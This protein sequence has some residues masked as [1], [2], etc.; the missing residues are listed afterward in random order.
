MDIALVGPHGA[1]KTTCGKALAEQLG[2][3]FAPEIGRLLSQDLSWRAADS[4]ATRPQLAF[5]REVLNREIA[6]DAVG[7]GTQARVIETWHPGN[8]AYILARSADLAPW[9]WQQSLDAVR[10]RP[11]LIVVVDCSDAELRRRQSEPGDFAFFARVGRHAERCALALGMP[12]LW[13][14][15]GAAS[16]QPQ[17]EQLVRMYRD[18]HRPAR[19]PMAGIAAL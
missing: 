14:I 19:P 13:R 9:A 7:C 3:P 12:L 18:Y 11:A 2:L 6:R 5:D 4:D 15:D 1:G 17:L 16:L 8:L 10:R